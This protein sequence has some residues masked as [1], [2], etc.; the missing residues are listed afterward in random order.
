MARIP[1]VFTGLLAFALLFSLASFA[2]VGPGPDPATL[3]YFVINATYGGQPVPDGTT[4]E[5]HC[6]INGEENFVPTASLYCESGICRNSGWYKFSPCIHSENATAVFEFRSESFAGNRSI[7]T[8][9]VPVTGG[10]TAHYDAALS[11]DGTSSM[12]RSGE[13]ANPPS[14]CPIS[15]ALPLLALLGVYCVRAK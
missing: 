3:P 15:L 13:N 5:I 14:T 9:A 11:P 4:A 10:V 7:N 8:T 6:L 2:D 1:S 12:R